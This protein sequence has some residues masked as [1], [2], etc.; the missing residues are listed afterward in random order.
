MT[1]EKIPVKF[2]ES[3]KAVEKKY[4]DLQL[5]QDKR[6]IE[7]LISYFI[8]YFPYAMNFGRE[9]YKVYYRIY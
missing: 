6:E 8:T 7:E 3:A 2:P 5:A 1:V 9:R 4:D